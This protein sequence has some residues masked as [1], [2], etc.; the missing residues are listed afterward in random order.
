MPKQR[1]CIL[2][3]GFVSKVLFL[4]KKIQ[5]RQVDKQTVQR[6]IYVLSM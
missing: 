1:E 2:F 5:T 6:F 3:T 4:F